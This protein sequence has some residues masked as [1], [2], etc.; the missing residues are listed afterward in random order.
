[1]DDSAQERRSRHLEW[2]SLPYEVGYVFLSDR[3][4]SRAD[5]KCLEC[6]QKIYTIHTL[7]HE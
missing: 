7:T 5:S 4:D 6:P 3:L 2:L 1:M